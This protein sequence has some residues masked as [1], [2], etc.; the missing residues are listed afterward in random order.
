M[1]RASYNDYSSRR[2]R[3][4]MGRYTSRGYSRSE[5]MAQQLKTLADQAPDEKTKQELHRM[6]AQMEQQK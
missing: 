3:D 4:S 6:A 2:G 1:Y 5:D